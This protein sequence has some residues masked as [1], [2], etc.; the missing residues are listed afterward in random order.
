LGNHT[1]D[2]E[3]CGRDRRLIAGYCCAEYQ[4][5]E[6]KRESEYRARVDADTEYLARFGLETQ[7]NALGYRTKLDADDVVA[8]LKGL[9]SRLRKR[10]MRAIPSNIRHATRV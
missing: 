9:E 3:F 2:C 1:I 6:E 10:G 8:F 4:A 7:S 5:Q